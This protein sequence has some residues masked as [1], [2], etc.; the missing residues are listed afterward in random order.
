MKRFLAMFLAVALLSTL[1]FGCSSGSSQ[2][3]SA[4]GNTESG[5]ASGTSAE[6]ASSS[7]N[8][9]PVTIQ[10]AVSGSA[11]ELDI[12]QQKFDLYTEEHPNVTI[13]PVDIG[14][15][16]FQKLM[17]LIGSG[18]APDIIYINEWC[19]SLAYRDVLMALDSFIEADEDFD[20]SYYPESLLVPL[21]YEDQLY[22]L[23]QEVSPYVIYYNK[24]M[25]EAAGLEMPTD[26]WTIDEFYEA[27]KALT[28]PEKNVY[29]YRYASGADPFLG[30]L[31]RAGVDFDTSGTE[32]QGLDTQEALNALEFLYNLVVVDQISPNPAALTAM[33][34]NADAMFRNQ[35]VAM[36]SMGLWML[37]QYKADPLSF[38]WDV[39]RMP[40]DQNQR[41]KA[42]IL[43]WGISADTK[44]PD[45]AWDLLKFLVGPES[46]EIVAESNM[47]LPA[48]T[49]ED[50]NQIVL[51]THFPENVKAFVDSVPDVD[52][53][54]QLSIYRTE[55]NTKL[56]ELVDK[57]LI[58]ESTPEETQQ[59][60]I[61]EI[62][63]ILAG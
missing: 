41:T 21:R 39:V 55:V 4:G 29:G 20:L 35:S 49:D 2:S 6:E 1:L 52:M 14:T 26:D 24:D 5:E 13:E 28:D 36:E 22:A 27:A 57:M 38:E 59:A 50:A 46:M 17:T 10:V 19:Y 53:T 63:A 12:H 44:N 23:P 30:W 3:S 61:K 62:N 60:L 51:D 56:Q 37:P 31:S 9:L 25:F 42:G 54:D 16:R 47:A 15:E 18:T 58:G 33:G 45:A 7:G 8:G 40:M 48:S 43:N 32:V 11:Q 34:T